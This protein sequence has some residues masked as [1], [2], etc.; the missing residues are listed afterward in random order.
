[1]KRICFAACALLAVN[2]C[3]IDDYGTSLV[4]DGNVCVSFRGQDGDTKSVLGDVE[5]LHG[6]GVLGVYDAETGIL[7]SE[8]EISDLSVP[9]ELSLPARRNMD[10]YLAAN[11]D[12]MGQDG[13]RQAFSFP[14][15]ESDLPD[16]RYMLD[17]S[18]VPGAGGG[19]RHRTFRESSLL[20]IPMSGSKNGV[21]LSCTREIVIPVRRL[22]AR[23]T[24]TIDH[25]GLDGGKSESFFRNSKLYLR[26]ANAVLMPFAGES[27]AF[28][29]E[30]LLEECDY[31]PEMVNGKSEVFTLYAPE[32]RKSQF[33]TYIEFTGEVDSAAGG[34]GGSVCYR[35]YVGPGAGEEC[36]VEGNMNYDITLGFKVGSLFEPSWK[37]APGNDWRDI[38]KFGI[39]ADPAG[40]KPLPAGQVIAVRPSR[41]GTCFVYF[42]KGFGPEDAPRLCDGNF[43]PEDLTDAG[44]S[45]EI[46]GLPE[47][48]MSLT[49]SGKRLEVS[50]SDPSGFRAGT[51]IPLTL[52]LYPGDITYRAMIR[53]YDDISVSVEDGKSLNDGFYV[54]MKRH[55]SLSGIA[56]RRLKCYNSGFADGRNLRFSSSEDAEQLQKSGAAGYGFDP[57]YGV[58]LFAWGT[59]SGSDL[60]LNLVSDDTFN[61]GDVL[62]SSPIKISVPAV[63][64][65]GYEVLYL[66]IDGSVRELTYKYLDSSGA[67]I[68]RMSFDTELYSRLLE[69]VASYGN[70]NGHPISDWVDSDGIGVWLKSLT[71]TS[72][73][74]L[75][76]C[77][78]GSTG[79]IGKVNLKPKVAAAAAGETGAYVCALLPK[80]GGDVPMRVESDYFDV[81]GPSEIDCNWTVYMEGCT[82]FE[83]LIYG[84]GAASCTVLLE[85]STGLES[86]AVWHFSDPDAGISQEVPYGRQTA[87]MRFRNRWSGETYEL[88]TEFDVVHNATLGAFVDFTEGSRDVNR[89]IVTT[90]K[91]AY[92]ICCSYDSTGGRNVETPFGMPDDS[93]NYIKLTRMKTMPSGSQTPIIE[94]GKPSLTGGFTYEDFKPFAYGRNAV[95]S[96]GNIQEFVSSGRTP[97]AEMKFTFP[98]PGYQTLPNPLPAAYS[99]SEYL[100][101]SISNTL[102]GYHIRR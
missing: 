6:G 25:S 3:I 63:S 57:G 27:V 49:V 17:G 7:D 100:K 65:D 86:R 48:G 60:V 66:G 1:M 23:I 50:V 2:A 18:E 46:E 28:S 96:A 94:Y 11:M 84:P 93:H 9:V 13:R 70:V 45:Y 30:D 97:F 58:D 14:E 56:G 78:D 59:A 80:F 52:H 12:Y 54:G 39:S 87:G 102:V 19:L 42:D 69:P 38:R 22:F 51:E 44:W 35:F 36:D 99:G 33:P 61:D 40:A 34:Y 73:V 10:F 15:R 20:G 95:W 55:I 64:H 67:E 85:P 29:E 5:A 41:P 26:Q 101:L 91:N 32:N 82:T 92:G 81:Y 83:P 24:L 79:M 8:F 68:D 4:T 31:E 74:S 62:L 76:D 47:N 72:G 88:S 53:T 37:V 16:L 71:S 43:F 90:A 77:I 89:I 21:D 75:M 98:G